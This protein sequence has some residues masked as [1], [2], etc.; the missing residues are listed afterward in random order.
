MSRWKSM[1][2]TSAVCGAM[3]LALLAGG[4]PRHA[5]L[6]QAEKPGFFEGKAIAEA[7][8]IYGLPIVMNYAVLY[9]YVIDRNSGQWKAPFNE[10]FNEHRVF[11][12]QDTT[13]VTPN[14]DTPYSLAWLDLHAEPLV[15][16]VP[17]VDKERYYAVMLCDG[18][19]FNYA[20][21]GSRATGNE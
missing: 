15:L 5:A 11:T 4:G 8:F 18:N 13:I 6:A 16:S 10:I 2:S 7:G 9:E 14:S 20:Y 17:A 21:I 3:V 12:Y 19:T 1:F